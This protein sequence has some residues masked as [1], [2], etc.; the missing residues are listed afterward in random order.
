[1]KSVDS[2]QLGLFFH[3]GVAASTSGADLEAQ[4]EIGYAIHNKAVAS[5]AAGLPGLASWQVRL[6]DN[7]FPTTD[8]GACL[9]P[10]AELCESSGEVEII[11]SQPAYSI[12][13]HTSGTFP[14]DLAQDLKEYCLAKYVEAAGSV[15]VQ[16]AK[17]QRHTSWTDTET[18]NWPEVEAATTR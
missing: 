3:I 10:R 13:F 15:P 4:D 18:V 1:M 9:Y 6:D 17:A 7:G 14:L 8:K 11:Q 2:M 12:W 5:V 16:F